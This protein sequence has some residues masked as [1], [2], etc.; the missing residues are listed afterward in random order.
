[1]SYQVRDLE[2]LAIST[3][4]RD[5][6]QQTKQKHIIEKII[7]PFRNTVDFTKNIGVD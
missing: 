2:I 3:F 5:I 7:E 4:L 6:C 1:M